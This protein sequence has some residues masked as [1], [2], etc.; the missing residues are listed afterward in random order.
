MNVYVYPTNSEWYRFLSNEPYVDEVN[1]W[2]P[3]G[4]QPFQQ[5]NPGD[6]LLF[7]LT[8]PRPAIAGGGTYTHF[9]FAPL[10]KS[11]EAFGEKNGTATFERLV[12]LVGKYRDL[13]ETPEQVAD[14][15][16]GNIV[17]TAPFF[18]PP[19]RRIPVPPDYE[20]KSSMNGLAWTS[21]VQY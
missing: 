12:S 7:R 18:L 20:R 3:G 21:E 5:L 13:G 17:L 8:K 11:W 16:I 6:L 19:D 15:V 4:K 1:F 14:A 10:S 9:S 2:R